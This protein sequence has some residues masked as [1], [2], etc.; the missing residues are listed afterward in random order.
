MSEPTNAADTTGNVVV[1]ETGRGKFQQEVVFGSHRLIADEPA[2]VGGLDSGRTG[3]SQN[4]GPSF[5]GTWTMISMPWHHSSST[6]TD[7]STDEGII[8]H[9]LG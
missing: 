4:V 3:L 7:H 9:V 5:F 6:T 8:G 2:N 1:R